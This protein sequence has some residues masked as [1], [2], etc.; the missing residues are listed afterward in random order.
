MFLLQTSVAGPPVS[1][2]TPVVHRPAPGG[3]PLRVSAPGP[4]TVAVYDAAGRRV[5]GLSLAAGSA[6]HTIR[7]GLRN[8]AGGAG[9]V[10]LTAGASA[11]RRLLLEPS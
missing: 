1:C 6:D 11:A 7:L 9:L 8:L 3:R 2:G 5:R 10:R 4:A